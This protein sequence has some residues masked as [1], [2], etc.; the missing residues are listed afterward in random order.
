VKLPNDSPIG[1]RELVAYR[2]LAK[3]LLFQLEAYRQG[4]QVAAAL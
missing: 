4:P 2:A 3:P 1:G